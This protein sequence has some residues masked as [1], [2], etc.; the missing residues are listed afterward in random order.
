MDCTCKYTANDLI[1]L[2]ERT[3][4]TRARNKKNYD[5][6]K[7]GMSDDEFK[8]LKSNYNKAYRERKKLQKMSP[9]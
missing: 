6:F 3:E 8:A 1:K 9:E 2:I 7:S 5:K 4:K